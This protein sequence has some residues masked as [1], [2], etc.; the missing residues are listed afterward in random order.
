MIRP[1][2]QPAEGPPIGKAP[3]TGHPVR[4]P[5]PQL[6]EVP[7][8]VTA[9]SRPPQEP[10]VNFGGRVRES[11]R[12]RARMYAAANDLDLQDILDQ[13]LTEFLDRQDA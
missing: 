2:R 5:D 11:L 12:R 1:A 10:L 6:E 8:T 9:R 13:A 4:Q 3:S 7:L